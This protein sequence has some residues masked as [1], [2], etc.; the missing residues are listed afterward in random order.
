MDK[1]VTV[2][3]ERNGIV[4]GM[5]RNHHLKDKSLLSV[6]LKK[7]VMQKGPP[8]LG[9]T[10]SIGG[11]GITTMYY[12]TTIFCLGNYLNLIQKLNAMIEV[13]YGSIIYYVP[14]MPDG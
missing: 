5:L 10:A 4:C 12:L 9:L 2:M 3:L 13:L 11:T 7:L 8:M 6:M 1:P 14:T